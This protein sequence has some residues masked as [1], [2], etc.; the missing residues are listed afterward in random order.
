MTGMSASHTATLQESS[1]D[2]P[3]WKTVAGHVAA[4]IVALIFL[5]AGIFKIVAP[6]QVQQLFEQLLIPAQFSMPL[7]LTLGVVE[8]LAGVLVLIPRYRRW[9]AL[10]GSALLLAFMIYIGARYYSLVGR[11]CSCFP[12][13]KRAVG[14]AFFWEDAAMLAA[15]V[16]A[17][18]F[19][20]KPAGLRAPAMVLA[21]LIVFSGASFGY[22]TAQQSG[23]QVP[24]SITVDGKP[25]NLREGRVFLWFYDP[26]CSH[27]EEAARH[28]ATYKW[29]SDVTVIGL[30]TNQPQWAESFLHDT[31][32]SARTS[33]DTDQMRKLFTFNYPPYGVSIDRGRVKGIVS[34]YDAPQ[35][36]AE[37]RGLGLI[38]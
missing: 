29:K 35:P 4:V 1:F 15:G 7:V 14:P 10:L 23:I 9:G 38:E 36:E 17:A 13:V 28:M 20:R 34:H 16:V 32:F 30:P 21:G 19:S 3:A 37:L 5:T 11:D 2:L 24:A 6:F 27:C 22:N 18:L 8:T 26:Q 25:Y 31:K 12:W 33:L